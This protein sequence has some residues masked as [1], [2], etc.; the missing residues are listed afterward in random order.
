MRIRNE[1]NERRQR[2]MLL[3]AAWK[4]FR[5]KGYHDT[6][7]R[8][9]LTEA[10]CSKGRFYYYFNAKAELLDSLSEVFDQKY[11]EFYHCVSKE[12]NTLEQLLDLT[13]RMFEFMVS[14]I[15]VELL[16]NLY[17]SQLSG[18]TEI[19]F[20]GENRLVRRILTEM[21]EEG[22]ARNQIRTD[23]DVSEMVSDIIEEERNQIISWCLEKG[24]YSL[25]EVSL[26][27]LE[28]IYGIYSKDWEIKKQ[29]F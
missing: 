14:E 9:I 18:V 12:K 21:L 23:I 24:R 1:E 27:K 28:R 29:Q 19:R 15:G 10:N 7:M 26:R 20:W 2:E 5:Q 17:I 13:R 22:Q 4:L 16:T 8:D 11:V 25:V 3:N 6:T